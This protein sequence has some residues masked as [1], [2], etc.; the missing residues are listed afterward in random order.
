MACKENEVAILK[1]T[2]VKLDDNHLMLYTYMFHTVDKEARRNGAKSFY[3]YEG[4]VIK[5][6]DLTKEITELKDNANAMNKWVW[7]T[8]SATWN[9]D[10]FLSYDGDSN[11]LKASKWYTLR[12]TKAI[13]WDSFM[14]LTR[15]GIKMTAKGPKQSDSSKGDLNGFTLDDDTTKFDITSAADMLKY[16]GHYFYKKVIMKRELP[17]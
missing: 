3:R 16:E 1:A 9:K 8:K 11:N 10:W 13:D 7:P 14:K 5:I 15:D 17:A 4:R 2:T 6:D 12:I